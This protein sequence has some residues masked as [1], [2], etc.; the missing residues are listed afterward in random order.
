MGGAFYVLYWHCGHSVPE[1][2][3]GS[4]TKFEQW[5]GIPQVIVGGCL[6][7]GLQLLDKIG[8]EALNLVSCLKQ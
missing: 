4:S 2:L 3:Q 7:E 1:P 6:K 5:E 8:Y